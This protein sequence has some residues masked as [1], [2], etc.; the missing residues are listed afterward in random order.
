MYTDR[1][2]KYIKIINAAN[3]ALPQI[4]TSS[5]AEVT[6]KSNNKP[7]NKQYEENVLQQLRSILQVLNKQEDDIKKLVQRVA[8]LENKVRG[9]IPK[10]KQK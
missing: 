6:S 7:D 1:S 3:T 2:Y 4:N 9:N 10:P 5:Y 8:K